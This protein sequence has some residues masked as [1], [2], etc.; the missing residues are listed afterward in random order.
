MDNNQKKIM[1]GCEKLT[2]PEEISALKDYLKQ[3]IQEKED[4]LI[5]GENSPTLS[6]SGDPILGK[7]DLNSQK[8]VLIDG[9]T[10]EIERKMVNLEVP[11]GVKSLGD[12]L[13]SID[14][15][16]R[17]K[18]AGITTGNMVSLEQ[19]EEILPY[20]KI[21]TLTTNKTENLQQNMK[22]LDVEG[23]N[24][25][26]SSG[27]REPLSALSDEE[28]SLSSFFSP[29]KVEELKNIEEK[30]IGLEDSREI[31]ISE[32]RLDI[33][34][35]YTEPKTVT[36]F[37]LLEKNVEPEEELVKLSDKRNIKLSEKR[38]DL[39]E[40]KETTLKTTLFELLE[41]SVDPSEELI[42][43]SGKK[44]VSPEE[45]YLKTPEVNKGNSENKWVGDNSADV[46]ELSVSELKAD[47]KLSNNDSNI[48]VVSENYSRKY[49]GDNNDL[50][51]K[52]KK[53]LQPGIVPETSVV[54]QNSDEI[55]TLNKPNYERRKL[56]DNNFSISEISEH[57]NSKKALPE[58][59][60]EVNITKRNPPEN[61]SRRWENFGD[62]GDVDGDACEETDLINLPFSDSQ[63][64]NLTAGD[65]PEQI[66][67]WNGSSGFDLEDN[68]KTTSYARNWFGDSNY[69]VEGNDG[70]TIEDFNNPE[71]RHTLP[72]SDNIT[73]W[74]GEGVAVDGNDLEE[75]N[76][77]D[78]FKF[79]YSRN[80]FGDNNLSEREVN[81]TIEDFNNPETRHTLPQSDNITTW[82]GEGI[83][84]VDLEDNTK[85]TSYTR[86]G[87]DFGD[88]NS[89]SDKSDLKEYIDNIKTSPG[90]YRKSLSSN[91]KDSDVSEHNITLWAPGKSL[92]ANA[93]KGLGGN[94]LEETNSS[95]NFKFKYSRNWFGDNNYN[96]LGE[97]GKETRTLDD[98]DKTRHTLPPIPQSDNITT[99]SGEGIDGVDL[100]NT[101]TT[102]YT[103]EGKNFGDNNSSEDKS[104]LKDYIN[105]IETSPGDHLIKRPNW[106]HRH[107]VNNE[108]T[109]YKDI[110]DNTDRTSWAE[111]ST[112]ADLPSA[113]GSITNTDSLSK[114]L[115]SLD[116]IRKVDTET[117]SDAYSTLE[118]ILSDYGKNPISGVLGG[119]KS[120][121]R[122]GHKNRYQGSFFD[123]FKEAKS[124]GDILGQIKAIMNMK[125]SISPFF[126]TAAEAIASFI[127]NSEVKQDVIDITLITLTEIRDLARKGLD[128]IPHR[129]P[130]ESDTW[131]GKIGST[132]GTNPSLGGLANSGMG[133]LVSLGDQYKNPVNRPQIDKETQTTKSTR[134]GV[135]GKER[136]FS[137]YLGIE[138]FENSGL[139][140]TKTTNFSNPSLTSEY[141]EANSAS[142]SSYDT[143]TVAIGLSTTFEDLLPTINLPTGVSSLEDLKR[144][145]SQ[146]PYITT[147]DK[148]KN[149][150]MT[151]DS[152][153]VWEIRLFPY[154]GNLNGN[155]SWLPSIYEM[156]GINWAEHRIQ[157]EWGEW[158][159]ASSFELQSKKMTQKTLGL[160]DG[161]ISFPV[162]MEFTNEVRITFIDDQLKTWKRY[163][164]LCAECSTYLSGMVNS[165]HNE[166]VK[167]IKSRVDEITGRIVHEKG[168]KLYVNLDKTD[169]IDYSCTTPV[170]KGTICP[171]MY[172]NLSFRCLIYVMNPQM[173]T[174]Q[175]FD[176]LLVMKD[177]AIEYTGDTDA[178]S[179]D[180]TVSFSVVGENPGDAIPTFERKPYDVP[181]DDTSFWEKA[182][183]FGLD[184]VKKLGTALV[185]VLS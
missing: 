117:S 43:L 10:V 158:I 56:G 156:N 115:I 4:S 139:N 170:V 101:K 165:I 14:K 92:A 13:D 176:L 41:N 157:T 91:I 62:N 27:Y 150:K 25:D 28:S 12:H 74:S 34:G 149:M 20:E 123:E 75:E 112:G 120:G 67:T 89:S 96:Y 180:L 93:D 161:E 132:I 184:I 35:N 60:K 33:K 131:Y 134:W 141:K 79:N 64:I 59:T 151:L 153:H 15:N 11:E 78:N 94:D 177:Y 174:I 167:V 30:V 179:P 183:D 46:V 168:T 85:T 23:K 16:S 84:G 163:F 145:L 69:Y 159:P 154:L 97:D 36:L 39:N 185:D 164:E 49:K 29:L 51:E 66:T 140:G 21:Q 73:T 31:K 77:N 17:T 135:K 88:N 105:N 58:E 126:R 113:Q 114:L 143:N 133:A 44:V 68:T 138:D 160:F 83:D 142:T 7:V 63:K 152:N 111:A 76:K 125:F 102:S 26:V 48:T 1:P 86:E 178:N 137:E 182:G 5:L 129:L 119:K 124:E 40:P 107:I 52:Y 6:T 118:Q 32:K 147:A 38:V 8:M 173:S 172:K 3:G 87:K 116:E 45:G 175:K 127:K 22:L 9:S 166:D 155:C 24:L 95:D 55:T 61:Y 37:E 136:Y 54:P 162:S 103:R 2:K 99:W 106:R 65:D 122:P 110:D 53:V 50:E 130:G 19:G 42:G 148:V 47:N 109:G 181:K 90:N 100:D 144:L 104:D 82:S 70:R 108:D 71:T 72:Q 57:G 128:S 171:G 121:K 98:F 169:L 80:W 18:E 146:S 81:R